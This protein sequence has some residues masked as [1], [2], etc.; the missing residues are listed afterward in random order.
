ME[1]QKDFYV[2]NESVFSHNID[3]FYNMSLSLMSFF[4]HLIL[5]KQ[6]MLIIIESA[7]EGVSCNVCTCYSSV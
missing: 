4:L 7:G 6:M 3:S 5:L 1:L 2:T